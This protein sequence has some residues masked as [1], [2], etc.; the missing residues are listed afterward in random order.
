MP[1]SKRP[2]SRSQN[3]PSDA[4]K[5]KE[6]AQTIK[7]LH[8]TTLSSLKQLLSRISPLSEKAKGKLT[9]KIGHF[10]NDYPNSP[11][12]KGK[13][14]PGENN[15]LRC[16]GASRLWVSSR[17]SPFQHRDHKT[18]NSLLHCLTCLCI[19]TFNIT[20]QQKSNHEQPI[21]SYIA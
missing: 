13:I 7:N 4:G 9:P 19:F 2:K 18:A 12:P 5:S 14:K 17:L 6:N 20:H 10:Y 8:E 1:S 11:K 15:E 21:H 3:S 16:L